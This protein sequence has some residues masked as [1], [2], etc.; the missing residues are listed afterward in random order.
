MRRDPFHRAAV[1]LGAKLEEVGAE[2]LTSGMLDGGVSESFIVDTD[3]RFLGKVGVTMPNWVLKASVNNCT[4]GSG[5]RWMRNGRR[6]SN[7]RR[8]FSTKGARSE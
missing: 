3:H 7:M 2:G 6:L 8:G 4:G 5:K 1:P